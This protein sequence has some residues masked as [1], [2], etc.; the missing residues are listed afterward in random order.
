MELQGGVQGILY[1]LQLSHSCR[2]PKMVSPDTVQLLS[3][4][5]AEYFPSVLQNEK[6]EQKLKNRP[7]SQSTPTIAILFALFC[8]CV[9]LSFSKIGISP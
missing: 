7:N 9:F 3:H 4:V 6:S 5:L 1:K 2:V 8:P